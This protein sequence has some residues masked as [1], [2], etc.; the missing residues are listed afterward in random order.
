MD[1]PDGEWAA[2]TWTS[3]EVLPLFG[4]GKEVESARAYLDPLVFAQEYEA[5]FINFTG[6]AYYQFNRNTHVGRFKKYYNPKK[7]I[8]VCF[9]FN[10]SPGI[11]V[12][13]QEFGV[14]VFDIPPGQTITTWIGEVYIPRNSNTQIVCNK[15]I[16]DWGGHQGLVICYGDSTGGNK[17]TAKLKGSDWDIIK[18]TLYPYFGTQLFFNVPKA[19]PLERQRINAVNSRLVAGNG[20]VRM[21]VDGNCE[22]LT[23]DFEGTRVLEGSAGEIDKKTDPL[24]SHMT[25]AIGYYTH[26][27]YPIAKWYKRDD[28]DAL[29]KQKMKEIADQEREQ[30][31]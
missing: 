14:D 19:N 9:D 15:I 5:S 16:K 23:K 4:R 22:Y 27:E 24:L 10:V 18:S 11:A 31:A 17:G 8:I 21:L 1:N 2:Y 28:I 12:I 7:P 30:A 6:M 29:Y 25:D 20:D 13:G 26:K 3:S